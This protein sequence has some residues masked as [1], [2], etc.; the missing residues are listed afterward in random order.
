MRHTV[1]QCLYIFTFVKP[2]KI[3]YSVEAGTTIKF[4]LVQFGKYNTIDL[5]NF[6]HQLS[7]LS[8]QLSSEGGRRDICIPFPYTEMEGQ[9]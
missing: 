8:S 7:H 2:S 5:Y 6:A 4:S 1:V 3:I 9:W